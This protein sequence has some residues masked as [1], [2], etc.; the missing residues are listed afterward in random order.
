MV[1]SFFFDIS[2][3]GGFAS[4]QA[5]TESRRLVEALVRSSKHP[6]VLAEEWGLS[7]FFLLYQHSPPVVSRGLLIGKTLRGFQ[8]PLVGG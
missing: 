2:K 5:V 6:G 4:A 7:C 3:H 8:K 1:V